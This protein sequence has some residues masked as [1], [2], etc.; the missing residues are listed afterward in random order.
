MNPN[1]L[2]MLSSLLSFNSLSLSYLS[3]F[4]V[5]KTFLFSSASHEFTSSSPPPP[6]SPYFFL[7]SVAPFLF[8]SLCF[9]PTY[10]LPS[11]PFLHH[12]LTYPSCLLYSS[13]LFPLY[14]FFHLAV[15]SLMFHCVYW[16]LY[17]RDGVG[18][19]SLKILGEFL[20]LHW[21]LAEW[22]TESGWK[23]THCRSRA[24]EWTMM[25]EE[26]L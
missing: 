4:L 7:S 21:S 22:L 24:V 2:F 12:L 10:P 26:T 9:N 1:A 13:F 3:H 20:P 18:N 17:A 25:F 15:L 6:N 19:G 8:P 16:G 23:I 11:S 14:I 5:P